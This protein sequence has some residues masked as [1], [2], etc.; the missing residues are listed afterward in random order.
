M[1]TAYQQ[2]GAQTF[3]QVRGEL[4]QEGRLGGCEVGARAPLVA[5]PKL[6]AGEPPL[7][8]RVNFTESSF[9]NS[10]SMNWGVARARM[11]STTALVK[12]SVAGSAVAKNETSTGITF[13][14]RLTVS[15][16]NVLESS[17]A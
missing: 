5:S 16:L 8:K 10:F 2:G 9:R 6:S 14:S 13:R 12:S 17:P 3:G 11:S 7:A 15:T 1:R 4:R